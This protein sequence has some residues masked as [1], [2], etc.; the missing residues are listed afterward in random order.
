M[1]IQ[2]IIDGQPIILLFHRTRDAYKL[3]EIFPYLLPLSDFIVYAKQIMNPFQVHGNGNILKGRSGDWII[4]IRSE[5]FL[6][7]EKAFNE[8][9]VRL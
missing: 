4:K 8:A 2:V 9:F 3:N 6:S 1:T 7:K 5:Y